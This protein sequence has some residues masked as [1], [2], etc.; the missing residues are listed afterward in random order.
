MLDG[1]HDIDSLERAYKTLEYTI[2]A[3]EGRPGSRHALFQLY[4]FLGTHI[5]SMTRSAESSQLQN[6][7]NFLRR[8]GL[9]RCGLRLGR[10]FTDS[11]LTESPTSMHADDLGNPLFGLGSVGSSLCS[12][13]HLNRL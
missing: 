2:V 10:Q 13:L 1:M 8:L 12:N 4:C 7:M 9:N 11:S 3:S 6:P 5:A